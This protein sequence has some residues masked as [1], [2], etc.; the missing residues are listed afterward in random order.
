[1]KFAQ[2]RH[3]KNSVSHKSH[4]NT[5]SNKREKLALNEWFK[6][7][8]PIVKSSVKYSLFTEE[9]HLSMWF[10]WKRFDIVQVDELLLVKFNLKFVQKHD[11]NSA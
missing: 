4:I 10:L 2:K 3:D 5:I 11:R 1:L 9:F 7:N 8:K 6:I